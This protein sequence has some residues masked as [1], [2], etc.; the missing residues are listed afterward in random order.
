LA[1]VALVIRIDRETCMGSGSCAFHAPGT[2]DLDDSMKAVVIDAAGDVES[3][4][5]L[6]ADGCPT[7]S[8]TVDE[9]RG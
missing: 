6:A 2:F 8:I 9:A 5:R 4:I 1:A 7:R 3:A